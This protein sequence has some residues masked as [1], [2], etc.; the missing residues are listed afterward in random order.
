M[1]ALE[2]VQRFGDLLPTGVPIDPRTSVVKG[3][4]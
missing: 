2:L 1:L 3:E 4:D